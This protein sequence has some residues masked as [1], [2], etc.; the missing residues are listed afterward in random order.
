MK[1][2]AWVTTG[3]ICIKSLKKTVA[4]L[5]IQEIPIR[6]KNARTNGM[7]IKNVSQ[8]NVI[9]PDITVIN[10]KLNRLKIKF[11]DSN[12]TFDIIKTN[13]GIYIFLIKFSL[14][15]MIAVELFITIVK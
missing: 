11:T 5:R 6:K 2:N 8:E 7:I 12:S 4:R 15:N 3:T 14:T 10:I 13:L 9:L 1:K